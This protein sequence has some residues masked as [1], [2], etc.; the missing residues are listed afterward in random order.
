MQPEVNIVWL[1]RDL[2]I[3][4]HAALYEATKQENDAHTSLGVATVQLGYLCM[5]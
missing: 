2:R 5:V 1:K 3:Q 4:D